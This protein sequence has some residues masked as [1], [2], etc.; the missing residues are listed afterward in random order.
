MKLAV[1]ASKARSFSPGFFRFEVI[2]KAG[3]PVC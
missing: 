3:V 1:K 2:V